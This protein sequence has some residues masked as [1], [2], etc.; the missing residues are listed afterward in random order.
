MLLMLSLGIT[1]GKGMTP[2][3]PCG[4]RKCRYCVDT[5]ATI[6]VNIVT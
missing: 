4:V 3:D 2:R 5:A 6:S 1:M